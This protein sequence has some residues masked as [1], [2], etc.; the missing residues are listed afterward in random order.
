MSRS[1]TAFAG[2]FLLLGL[3]GCDIL[4]P[5]GGRRMV[6]IIDWRSGADA[7]F[8]VGGMRS[9]E[10]DP[11]LT[12]V[13]E[14]PDTVR[15]GE[16]FIIMITTTGLNSCWEPAG[17]TVHLGSRGATVT[18]Y[19]RMS[20]EYD[21]LCFASHLDLP[22]TLQLTLHQQGEQVIRIEGRSVVGDDLRG[23]TDAVVE[24]PIMV[25]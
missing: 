5:D 23:A 18:P 7:Q 17:A 19:D 24:K 22:R 13:L 10:Y 1:V 14:A 6:G 11:N 2:F 4:G 16:P 21:R 20:T 9:G 12:P 3:S 25:R 15:A 8:A